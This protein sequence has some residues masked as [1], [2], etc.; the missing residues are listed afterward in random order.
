[1]SESHRSPSEHLTNENT[2]PEPDAVDPMQFPML[3]PVKIMGRNEP[4]FTDAVTEI[5]HKHID[6][7]NPKT[8]ETRTSKG[9]TYLSLTATFMAQSREQLDALYRELSAHPLVS[10]LI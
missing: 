6:D 8:L 2:R 5:L 4:G 3:F 10:Y 1:M 9:D 7:F